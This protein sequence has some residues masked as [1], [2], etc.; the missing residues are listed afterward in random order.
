MT[1]CERS[2]SRTSRPSGSTR[3]LET[4]SSAPAGS[5]G[6]I[7]SGL[8]SSGCEQPEGDGELSIHG[9]RV[10]GNAGREPPGVNDEQI[11][12]D[13]GDAGNAEEQCNTCHFGGPPFFDLTVSTIRKNSSWTRVSSESSG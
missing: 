9:G 12:A 1:S 10:R 5:E 3:V 2:V 11:E 4:M 6:S 13:Q 8:P 7:P